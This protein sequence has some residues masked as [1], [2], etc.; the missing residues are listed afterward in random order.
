MPNRAVCS[1]EPQKL[2]VENTGTKRKAA[3]EAD[4]A[5]CT[6]GGVTRHGGPVVLAEYDPAWPALFD[7]EALRIRQALGDVAISI[8]HVG[9]TSVPGLAAKPIID[10]VIEVL[11]SSDEPAYLPPLESR[12]YSLRIREPHWCEHRML[13]GP[14]T[15][16][17]LHVF[18]LGC[19][20]IKRMLRFRD[21]LRANLADREIYESRKRELA[22]RNWTYIQN[23][24]DAKTD[25]IEEIIAR[26]SGSVVPP[27]R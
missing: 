24:A 19:P 21:H 18:T 10:I 8:E 15:D 26:A 3:T 2:M 25:V 7:R 4:L 1:A 6:I 27:R 17:N 22:A 23:Y 16:M 5:A 13:K 11:D 12:G 20:E 14:D 9:S